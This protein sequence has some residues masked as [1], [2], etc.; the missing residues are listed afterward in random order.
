[1]GKSSILEETNDN[2][3]KRWYLKFH[4]DGLDRELIYFHHRNFLEVWPE[5][6]REVESLICTG[7][8]SISTLYGQESAIMR[9]MLIKRCTPIFAFYGEKWNFKHHCGHPY[10]GY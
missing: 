4:Y 1:K 5:E 9:K 10:D 6:I 8:F 2:D 7:A 3:Q